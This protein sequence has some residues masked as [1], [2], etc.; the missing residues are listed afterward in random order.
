[1]KMT[2]GQSTVDDGR[3]TP[4]NQRSANSVDSHVGSR[5]RLRRLELG[6]SQEKL[7]DQLGITFQQVQKYE[8]GTN[9]IGASRLHQIAIV[10]Q[11]PITYFFEG[12]A[13]TQ[14]PMNRET[15]PLSRALND[16]ATVRLVRAFASINDAQLKQKAVGIIE[17]IADT[18]SVSATDEVG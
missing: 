15:T 2:T 5:V 13:D 9:R 6:L 8:R 4:P 12:A 11:A 18:S 7:A 1:M 16:P 17:A 3:T 14:S 10:L